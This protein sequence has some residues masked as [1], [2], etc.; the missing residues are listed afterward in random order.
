MVTN[1]ASTAVSSNEAFS[2]YSSVIA[3]VFGM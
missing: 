2:S 3:N 1:D